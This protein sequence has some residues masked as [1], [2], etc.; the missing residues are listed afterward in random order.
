MRVLVPGPLRSYTRGEG[1]VTA[2]GDRLADVVADLDAQ[3]PGLRF[4][5]LDEQGNIRRHIRFFLNATAVADLAP[6]VRDTDE[7]LIV[8][9]LSGG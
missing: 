4:R 6:P 2:H 1:I 5:I 3:F 8:C 9:A 7:V